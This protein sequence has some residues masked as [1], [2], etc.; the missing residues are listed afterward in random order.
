MADPILEALQAKRQQVM[1]RNPF[2][3]GG[4]AA[5]TDR[6][7]L[8]DP[9]MNAY[10]GLAK[11]LGGGLAVGYGLKQSE[12]ETAKQQAEL[13]NIVRQ[14]GRQP[15]ALARALGQ[16]QHWQDTAGTF[17]WQVNE[18]QRKAQQAHD[19]AL[20]LH[21]AKATD[22]DIRVADYQ[23]S[24]RKQGMFW[25]PN[26][27][28]VKAIPGYADVKFAATPEGRFV[29][30]GVGL[31]QGAPQ[32]SG[33]GSSAGVS[34]NQQLNR[35]RELVGQGVPLS[36]AF[37]MAEQY[38]EP[39]ARRTEQMSMKMFEEIGSAQDVARNAAGVMEALNKLPPD[40]SIAGAMLRAV[41]A[42]IVKDSDAADLKRRLNLAI[43]PMLKPFFPGAI[44]D[45][46]RRV[47]SQTMGGD[48]GVP[49]GTLKNIF[50][51]A[52]R[53]GID[54]ANEKIL[55]AKQGGY[56]I[57]YDPMDYPDWLRGQSVDLGQSTGGVAIA[58][59]PG[60]APQQQQVKP[61]ADV[62]SG[63]VFT[64]PDGRRVRMLPNGFAK[65][66]N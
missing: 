64:L 40:E 55:T 41:E 57:P 1:A 16:S 56:Y 10:M 46:E 49:V 50:E 13:A 24:L 63:G 11:A 19:Q 53:S 2:L 39:G 36:Q 22:T 38:P 9:N 66:L 30:G 47:L 44:S 29:G 25:D 59:S 6:T 31:Q 42:G 28:R 37:Q 45:E 26:E 43:F 3:L 23:D 33:A 62:A 27:G 61:I 58:N 18:E 4:S 7:Q 15:D 14:H 8:D 34:D 20:Q 54:R 17:A 35:V 65:P 51:R 48:L 32:V 21:R 52:T 5:L 60:G 12:A